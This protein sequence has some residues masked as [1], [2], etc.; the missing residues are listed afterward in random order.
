[1][2]RI[3]AGVGAGSTGARVKG[4]VVSGSGGTRTGDEDPPDPPVGGSTM[5]GL[6]EGLEEPVG[7]LDGT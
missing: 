3:G 6:D 2:R 1:V 5:E 7:A 4:T